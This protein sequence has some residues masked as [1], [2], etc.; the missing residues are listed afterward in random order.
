MSDL[1]TIN[2]R[3]FE[4]LNNLLARVITRWMTFGHARGSW[5]ITNSSANF[6]SY[7]SSPPIWIKVKSSGITASVANVRLIAYW[8]I[9]SSNTRVYSEVCKPEIY[10]MSR[11]QVIMSFIHEKCKEESDGELKSDSSMTKF[12]RNHY[13]AIEI[14]MKCDYDF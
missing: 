12:L 9:F 8:A 1:I 6:F 14:Q 2:W 4:C 11:S 3:Q 10:N 5:S 7:F 13:R